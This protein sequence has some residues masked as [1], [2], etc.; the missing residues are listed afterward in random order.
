MNRAVVKR[1][2]V[3]GSVGGLLAVSVA[4]LLILD[5]APSDAGTPSSE[6]ATESTSSSPVG[7][8]PSVARPN[9]QPQSL[10]VPSTTAPPSAAPSSEPAPAATTDPEDV[11]PQDVP[12]S[13]ITTP[14][15]VTEQPR[16]Q[17]VQFEQGEDIQMLKSLTATCSGL[18][19]PADEEPPFL[20]ALGTTWN[21]DVSAENF[22]SFLEQEF[23]AEEIDDWKFLEGCEKNGD[24]FYRDPWDQNQVCTDNE[25]FD[26]RTEIYELVR[27]SNGDPTY[28]L[29]KK[30]E[31]C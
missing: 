7:R 16:S 27:A 4:A 14:S 26:P 1:S 15:D 25:R 17:A 28:R 5:P 11:P 13:P 8:N 10:P 9:P 20:I 24:Y 21:P 30:E 12:E 2:A 6:V 31:L 19:F 18:P 23:K 29:I 22:K 3:T